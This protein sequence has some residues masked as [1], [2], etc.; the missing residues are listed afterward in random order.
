MYY[1]SKFTEKQLTEKELDSLNLFKLKNPK[2]DVQ[3]YF[4]TY[5]TGE[6]GFVILATT[7]QPKIIDD[8]T[9]DFCN[10]VDI[11]DYDYRLD[12]Y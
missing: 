7:D 5:D 12:Q 10:Y 6:I 8:T 1:Y 11:T 9:C 4:S 2:K 3:I